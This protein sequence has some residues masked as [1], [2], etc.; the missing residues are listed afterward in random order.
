MFLASYVSAHQ[1]TF[2]SI[3]TGSTSLKGASRLY[4]IIAT[5]RG[6]SHPSL[7][8]SDF[9]V[10]WTIHGTSTVTWLCLSTSRRSTK[11]M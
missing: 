2:I 11:S 9:Y 7:P 8:S 1:Q 3:Q 10:W 5:L 6:N 4:Y